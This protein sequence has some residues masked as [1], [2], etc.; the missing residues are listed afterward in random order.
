MESIKAKGT[1]WE[2]H[3]PN[4]GIHRVVQRGKGVNPATGTVDGTVDHDTITIQMPGPMAAHSFW[5]HIDK[6]VRPIIEWE[7][8]A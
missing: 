2:H 1:R 5:F 4:L 3:D 7:D 8:E 6:F